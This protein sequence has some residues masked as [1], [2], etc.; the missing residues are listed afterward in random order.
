[1]FD[2]LS[3][4]TRQAQWQR[5]RA[6]LSWAEKVHQTERLRDSLLGLRRMHTRS[7]TTPGRRS[8]SVSEPRSF[9]ASFPSYRFPPQKGSRPPLQPAPVVTDVAHTH[10]PL[11]PSIRFRDIP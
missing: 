10:H 1:M 8:T 7:T 2:S 11:L 6:G 3:L 4:L 9:I 5:Q